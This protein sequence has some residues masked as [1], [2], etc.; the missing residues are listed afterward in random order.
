[1]VSG[2]GVLR[3]EG[4]GVLVGVEGDVGVRCEGGE[5]SVTYGRWG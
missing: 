1:L 2:W 4:A 3:F 5:W